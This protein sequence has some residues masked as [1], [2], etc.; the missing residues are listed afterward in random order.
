MVNLISLKSTTADERSQSLFETWIACYLLYD[1]NL[2]HAGNAFYNGEAKRLQEA[3]RELELCGVRPCSAAALTLAYNRVL[4][5][6]VERFM[7]A[8]LKTWAADR[9]ELE[10]EVAEVRMEVFPLSSAGIP[11]AECFFSNNP[12]FISKEDRT[13]EPTNQ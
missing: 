9:C 4:H 7:Q 13:D 12:Y 2:R 10:R 5:K 11:D 3:R 1:A 6:D 8:H